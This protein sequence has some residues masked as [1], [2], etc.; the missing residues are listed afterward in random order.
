MP[1]YPCVCG[2]VADEHDRLGKCEIDCPCVYFEADVPEDAEPLE[3][4]DA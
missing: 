2:H 1:E 3:F 4:P